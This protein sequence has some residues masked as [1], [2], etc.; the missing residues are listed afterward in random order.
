MVKDQK[1]TTIKAKISRKSVKT[2]HSAVTVKSSKINSNPQ[3]ME[4]LLAVSGISTFSMKKGDTVKGTIVSTSPKEIL[5]DIGKKSFGIVAEWELDQVRDYVQNL[6]SGDKV[7]AQVVNPE[8]EYGYTVLSLRKASMETRWQV[9]AGI[10]ETGEDIEV[11]GLETAKGGILVDWQG[12]RGFVPSTQL[13]TQFATSPM[14][15]LN[16]K[17]KVKVIELDQAIN[18]LV[19]S[20]KASVLGVTPSAQREKLKKIKPD[21]VLKGNVSGIAPFG[22]FVDVDGIE[23]LVH[24]SEVAWEKVEN[25]TDLYKVGNEVEVVVLD[26]NENEGKLNLSLKRLT[27]DP[28]KNILDR[29]PIE[30]G[31]SGKVVRSAPYGIFVQLEPGIEGLLHISKINPGEEPAIGDKVECMVE[32]IDTIKRKI[33]LTL[34]P[35]EKPVGYR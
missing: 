32:K 12:L 8:N 3:T 21:D 4:E 1:D 6:K 23:G 34:V 7:V 29:Y 20:Q 10:K 33:S 11:T 31:V 28:W 27:P 26:V 16:R 9:L 14:Q 19:L 5:V 24:I 17:I 2:E 13:E 30:A 25:L 18:R 35:K 15:L 22:V